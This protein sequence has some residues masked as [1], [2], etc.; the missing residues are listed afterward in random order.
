MLATSFET[1][2][3]R[4]RLAAGTEAASAL[5]VSNGCTQDGRSLRAMRL[6]ATASLHCGTEKGF[7][8]EKG[9]RRIVQVMPSR[10]TL[11]G[12]MLVRDPHVRDWSTQSIRLFQRSRSFPC[13]QNEISQP[14]PTRSEDRTQSSAELFSILSNWPGIE[15]IARNI[16]GSAV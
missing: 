15:P 1:R 13:R 10:D 7:A 5:T 12:D 16:H 14:G 11:V 3:T 4:T 2:N 9:A 6:T 8:N